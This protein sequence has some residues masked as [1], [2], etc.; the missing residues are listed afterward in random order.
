[1]TTLV[2]VKSCLSVMGIV[3]KFNAYKVSGILLVYNNV[4]LLS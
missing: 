1:M 3:T 2:K 4:S